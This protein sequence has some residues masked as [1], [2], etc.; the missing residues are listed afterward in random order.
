MGVYM[1]HKLIDEKGGQHSAGEQSISYYQNNGHLHPNEICV[2]DLYADNY[3]TVKQELGPV[4][5]KILRFFNE[6][7]HNQ[8]LHDM[9]NIDLSETAK[10]NDTGDPSPANIVNSH[11]QSPQRQSDI[12]NNHD[13]YNDTSNSLPKQYY[14]NHSTP[15]SSTSSASSSPPSP[16]STPDT[17]PRHPDA[18]PNPTRFPATSFDTAGPI[19]ESSPKRGV[20]IYDSNR[21]ASL[22]VSKIFGYEVVTA[23]IALL[24][25]L[26]RKYESLEKQESV[27]FVLDGYYSRAKKIELV[28]RGDGIWKNLVGVHKV[29]SKQGN[30][31]RKQKSILA[32]HLQDKIDSMV[33]SSFKLSVEIST[34]IIMVERDTNILGECGFQCLLASAEADAL[35]AKLIYTLPNAVA[36]SRDSDIPIAYP[37]INKVF[38]QSKYLLFCQREKHICALTD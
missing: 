13:N 38:R 16:H 4:A 3:T 15:P 12:T 32:K 7:R 19:L 11:P 22:K 14:T 1:G 21:V 31:E 34:A 18:L 27:I 29:K 20:P 35:I 37:F 26:R 2:I 30:A 8:S 6:G 33:K 28:K 9:M 10:I 24:I 5:A 36:F 17:R 23:I 25:T